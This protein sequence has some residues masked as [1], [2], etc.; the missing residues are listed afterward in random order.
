MNEFVEYELKIKAH[1][2]CKNYDVIEAIEVNLDGIL[3]DMKVEENDY[4]ARYILVQKKS[5]FWCTG[6]LSETAR[7]TNRT[8]KLKEQVQVWWSCL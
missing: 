8:R 1:N 2:K 5:I 4:T 6:C 3:D 7:F